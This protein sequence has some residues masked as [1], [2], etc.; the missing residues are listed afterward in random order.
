[1]L[2][3]WKQCGYSIKNLSEKLFLQKVMI[4]RVVA[5]VQSFRVVITIMPSV[6]SEKRKMVVT[7]V[8]RTRERIRE[9]GPK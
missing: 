3:N 2:N 6:F 7:R 8:A 4:I 1:M 5:S 9:Y